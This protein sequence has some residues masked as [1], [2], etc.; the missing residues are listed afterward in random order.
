MK[1]YF[2]A[3]PLVLLLCFGFACQDKA[4]MAELEKFKV[5]AKVE[6]Q[7]KE[8]AR[9]LFSA[10]DAN[11]FDKLRDLMT[12]DFKLFHPSLSTPVGLEETFQ[13]INGHYTAFPDWK[14][15]VEMMIAEGDKVSVK[16]F[17]QGTHKGVYE[18]IQPTDIKV[19]MPA[20]VVLVVSD[21]KV[22]EFWAVEDYLSFYQ[23][24]G[25]ELKPKE[26]KK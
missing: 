5:Q 3:V 6:E 14:H 25:F 21:G 10:I 8:L 7:N 26:V 20:Q 23:Q 17:Q 13:V 22:K 12:D 4:A 2:C 9:S 15:A 11:D 1:K 16:L 19:T 24:L 18:G